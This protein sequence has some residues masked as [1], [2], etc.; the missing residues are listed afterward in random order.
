[1]NTERLKAVR[2]AIAA[3]ADQYDQG[4]WLHECGTPA[5]IAGWA[6]FLSLKPG[7]RLISQNIAGCQAGIILD[8]NGRQVSIVAARATNW[9]GLKKLQGTEMFD[10]SPI[11]YEDEDGEWGFREANVD[12]ALSMLN[13]AIEAD[14]VDWGELDDSEV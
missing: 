11:C 14:I 8:E 6:A 12:E 5:C 9:L 10:A 7:E 13:R 2:A 3:N 4:L 1:M